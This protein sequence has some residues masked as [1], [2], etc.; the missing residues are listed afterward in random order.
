MSFHSSTI[1][2][3]LATTSVKFTNTHTD[4]FNQKKVLPSVIAKNNNSTETV[5]L[6]GANKIVSSSSVRRIF[7]N[8]FVNWNWLELYDGKNELTIEGNCEVT[9]SWREARKIGEY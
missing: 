4:F 3:N 5:V 1:N 7:G 6:D 9:L 2:P 8:D